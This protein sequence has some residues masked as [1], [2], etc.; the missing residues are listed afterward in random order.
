MF[1]IPRDKLTHV[2]WF[3]SRQFLKPFLVEHGNCMFPCV[4][5]PFVTEIRS[6]KYVLFTF[7][8]LSKL[9]TQITVIKFRHVSSLSCKLDQAS[10]HNNNKTLTEKC[11]MVGMCKLRNGN[12]ECNSAIL[13]AKQSVPLTVTRSADYIGPSQP[14]SPHLLQEMQDL[15]SCMHVAK[16]MCICYCSC[17]FVL[18][19]LS[20]HC[21][22]INCVPTVV[23]VH[24]RMSFAQD[25]IVYCHVYL[26]SHCPESVQHR[27]LH[28]HI[29][30]VIY[31]QMY[32][33][34]SNMCYIQYTP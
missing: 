3:A 25:S 4:C 20:L 11:S 23:H 13:M 17:L 27:L 10:H 32:M 33:Y 2:F 14:S 22:A 6:A 34:I 8:H 19:F 26:F 30:Q 12:V 31:V 28:I 18:L 24:L 15:V 21:K 29:R 1:C 7:I 16:I 9:G 5:I